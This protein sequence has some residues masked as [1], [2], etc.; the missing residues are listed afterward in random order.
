MYFLQR[1]HNPP[2]VHVI[3]QDETFSITISD[4][5]IIDGETKP[6]SRAL[7][8]VKEWI[9]INKDELLKMWET[10]EIHEL[11]PLK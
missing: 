11:E 7:E 8:M 4:L 10:Q 6:S 5:R 2:H 1:E 3:Y 9:E